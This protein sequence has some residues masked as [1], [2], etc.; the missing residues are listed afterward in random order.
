MNTENKPLVFI[1]AIK[2]TP[3]GRFFTNG[4]RCITVVGRAQSL[5][6]AN[7]QAYKLIKDKNFSSL[8]YRD[9]IGNKFFNQ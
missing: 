4:G 2:K 5:E 1:G 6:G 3:D 7:M 9:D 8:W